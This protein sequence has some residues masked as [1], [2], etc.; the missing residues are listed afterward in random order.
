MPKLEQNTIDCI[1]ACG[2]DPTRLIQLL[3]REDDEDD[4]ADQVLPRESLHQVIIEP[5]KG[6]RDI[7]EEQQMHK[8]APDAVGSAAKGSGDTA[9]PAHA[10]VSNEDKAAKNGG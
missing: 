2:E 10:K 3:A 6:L 8:D 4:E 9:A 1:L 5:V 7:M